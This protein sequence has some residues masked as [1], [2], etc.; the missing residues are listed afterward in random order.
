MR[1]SIVIPAFNEAK[2]IAKT[3]QRIKAA[4]VAFTR[5]GW[6]VE[7]IVCD[8]N[9]TDTTAR[10][11]ESEGARVV[12]EPVNQIARARNTGAAAATGDWLVFIDADSH[13]T[14][15]LF[16]D[17]AQQI[18]LGRCLAGGSTIVM[19]QRSGMGDWATRL[20]NTISRWRKWMAGSF[21]F[22]E[23]AVFREIGGFDPQLFASEELDLSIRL[24]KAARKAGKKVVILDRHPL[25]TSA[26]KVHLYSR[27]EWLRFLGKALFRPRRTIRSREECMPWYDG[28]R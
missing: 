17:V 21:I 27:L 24:K 23:T 15:E 12:F 1:I 16:A 25:V 14:S 6:D 2:L 13:P 11:A 10:L 19:D 9:S 20:W 5:I 26:R 18:E 7:M 8:N 4:T 3:L 28:R 22:C